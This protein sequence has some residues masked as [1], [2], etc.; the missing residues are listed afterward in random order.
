MFDLLCDDELFERFLSDEED[1]YTALYRRY[2]ARLLGYIHSLIGDDPGAE[3]LL[4]EAFIRLYRERDRVRSGAV[5]PV[6]NVG[7]WLFRVAR[8][9]SLNHIR[10][11]SYLAPLPAEQSG[12]LSVDIEESH[13]SLFGDAVHE[14]ALMQAV[15][16]AVAALPSTLREVFVLRE[17]NGL[18]YTEV[19]SIMG[20]SEEAARMRLSRA[21]GTI[22]T[23]LQPIL[24]EL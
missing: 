22:R 11:L 13:A 4:Q 24:A 20:I 21:R 2:G 3:D 16:K 7:G 5:E 1:A 14:Q 18:S 17:M 6:R 8:N 12:M 15:N 10:S 23:A 9:L 19:S